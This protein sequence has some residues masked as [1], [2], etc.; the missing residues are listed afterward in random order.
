V[1]INSVDSWQRNKIE[2]YTFNTIPNK[3]GFYNHNLICYKP[4]DDVY[5]K[6]YSFFLGGSRKIPDIKDLSKTC[7]LDE[8]VSKAYYFYRGLRSR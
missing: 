4:K 8:E 6:V 1:Q 5:Q 2:G 3:S 7:S